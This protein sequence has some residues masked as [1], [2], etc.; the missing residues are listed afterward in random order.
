MDISNFLRNATKK[1]GI[2]EGIET[3]KIKV[4][5]QLL[6]KDFS[7]QEIQKMSGLPLEFI[8]DIKKSFDNKE[9]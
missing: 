3:G 2:A 7:V 9:E 6:K 4:V 1:H 5:A 8:T